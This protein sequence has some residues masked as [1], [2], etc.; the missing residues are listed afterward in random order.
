MRYLINF[1]YDGSNYYGYQIQ[2]GKKTIQEELETAIYKINNVKRTVQSTGRTDRGVHAINQYAHVDIDID[3]T[4]KGLKRALNSRLPDDIYVKN[5]KVVSD[6]FH[7]RYNTTGKKYKYI[8]NLGE[9]NPIEKDYVFQYGHEL[10]ISAMKK[11]IKV[12]LG[13][14]DFR[15]FVTDS[16]D[17]E[18]CV[19]KITHVSIEE[20][21]EKIILNFEGTGFLRYQ[22]RNMVGIL[23]R[24]GEGK[25][26]SK[27]IEE[28]LKSK[29]RSK[30]GKTAPACGLYLVDVYFDEMI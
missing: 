5:V 26:S 2:P 16:K 24:V 8:M 12:F 22:V 14:H 20:K 30:S 29:D 11:A 28:V 7:A 21:D 25:L 17:K 15:A 3:I 18:N 23:I 4:E 19:R 9:Y 27:D 10:D 13:E 6:D 1:S